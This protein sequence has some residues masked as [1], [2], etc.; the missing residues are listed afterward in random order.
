MMF[1]KLFM[2]ANYLSGQTDIRLLDLTQVCN[3]EGYR[4]KNGNKVTSVKSGDL[5]KSLSSKSNQSLFS[6]YKDEE[7]K[8]HVSLTDKGI[9]QI[10]HLASTLNG[11]EAEGANVSGRTKDVIVVFKRE[12]WIIKN[13]PIRIKTL[14]KACHQYGYKPHIGDLKK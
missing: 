7:N 2:Y 13:S 14:W 11:C 6:F 4:C 1:A 12:G 9:K 8:A 3:E 10:E 5:Y